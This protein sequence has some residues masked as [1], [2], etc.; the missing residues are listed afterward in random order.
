MD[1]VARQRSTNRALALKMWLKSGRQMKLKDIAAE[2][3]VSD[4][5][6]R[7]WK[8]LDKWD[9]IPAKRPRGA[10]KGNKNAK[11]NKGGGAPKGN[12]NALKH[13]LYS[14][15]L[16]DDPEYQELLE[17]ASDMDP[18]D[19]LWQGVMLA[20]TKLIWAQRIMFVKS[21]E[22]MTRV[23]KRVKEGGKFSEQEWELQFAWD[24]QA[25]EIK[26]FAIASRELRSAIKQFLDMAPEHDERRAKLALMEAQIEKIRAET[27]AKE[28]SADD[29]PDDGFIEA[30]Q[31][32]AAEV[33][34]D[35]EAR[36]E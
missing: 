16:P 10:P 33:W 36:N 7:Q 34:N 15:F 28:G 20:Y 14:K 23:L 4:V 6:V 27:K 13:G 24:K 26:A 3:G 5:Q 25:N 2:L 35:D 32:K 30:L 1:V 9:E 19:I 21:K 31:G 29:M 18:L 22:D 11:G 12:K 17:I 8:Y